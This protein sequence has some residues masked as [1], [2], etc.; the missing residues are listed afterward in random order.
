M[1]DPRGVLSTSPR[2][3]LDEIPLMFFNREM[4][5]REASMAAYGKIEISDFKT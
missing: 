2:P 4:E 5:S 3:R 1:H